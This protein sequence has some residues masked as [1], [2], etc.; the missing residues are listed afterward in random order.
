M[1][2]PLAEAN[3]IKVKYAFQIVSEAGLCLGIKAKDGVLIAVERSMECRNTP[4]QKIFQVNDN[5]VCAV[6]GVQSDAS[7]LMKQ[8]LMSAERYESRHR[9]PM[10]CAE[11]AFELSDAKRT[12]N[13][14]DQLW[15][16]A[17]SI[18]YM[19]WDAKCCYQLIQSHPNGSYTGCKSACIGNKFDIVSAMLRQEL[20]GIEAITLEEA[21]Q[22]AIKVLSNS[23]ADFSA[24]NYEIATLQRARSRTVYDVLRGADV[25][26]LIR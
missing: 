7:L 2:N 12:Y 5:V 20:C 15:T 19:G 24:A 22:L 1:A 8:A 26:K 13:Q 4:S 25:N 6:T 10:S 18:L 17:V 3:L 21:K 9:R 14:A 11:V 23:F 16:L